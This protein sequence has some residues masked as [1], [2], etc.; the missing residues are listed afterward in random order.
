ML[1][2]SI[3]RQWVPIF[4]VFYCSREVADGFGYNTPFEWA[5]GSTECVLKAHQSKPMLWELRYRSCCSFAVKVE[6]SIC[7]LKSSFFAMIR[8]LGY[9][10]RAATAQLLS[11]NRHLPNLHC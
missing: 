1:V 7:Q 8:W 6:T 9:F 2:Y 10:L 11:L 4:V 3:K 5:G